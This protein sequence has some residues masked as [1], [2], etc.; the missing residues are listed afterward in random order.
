ML[1][2]PGLPD[3]PF[4]CLTLV[5]VATS[6]AVELVLSVSD[7]QPLRGNTHAEAGELSFAEGETYVEEETFPPPGVCPP[8]AY[9]LHPVGRFRDRTLLSLRV[10]PFRSVP[11][12]LLIVHRRVVLRATGVE[13]L[14]GWRGLRQDNRRP[15]GL[16]QAASAAH[17][18]AAAHFGSIHPRVRIIVKEDGFYRAEAAQLA[19]AGID[20]A[21]IDPGQLC[22]THSGRQLPFYLAGDRDGRFDPV[23]YLEFWGQAN[24]QTWQALAPDMYRDPYSDENTYWLSWEVPPGVRLSDEQVVFS[25]A[26]LT[27][28]RNARSFWETVH[29]EEDNAFNRLSQLLCDSLRDHWFHDTGVQGGG[30]ARISF[31][32]ILAGS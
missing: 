31:S 5:Q 16:P 15:Q 10:F 6:P 21:A 22:L 11:P 32:P 26:E 2:L 12:G 20:P 9:E 30:A 7:S 13:L 8:T 3:L 17:E 4:L 25:G 19:K 23:D 1:H 24:R 18:S 29:I 14:D 27:S 28:P